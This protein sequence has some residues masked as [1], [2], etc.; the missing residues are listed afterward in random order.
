MR[1]DAQAVAEFAMNRLDLFVQ[2]Y[3]RDGTKI[4]E[5]RFADIWSQSVTSPEPR[6]SSPRSSRPMRW[7]A[8]AIST[9]T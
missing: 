7:R 6:G 2:V 9:P 3:G 8:R 5:E 4:Y 1:I